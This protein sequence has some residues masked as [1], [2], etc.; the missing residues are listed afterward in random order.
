MGYDISLFSNLHSHSTQRK[1]TPN[2]RNCC[3]FIIHMLKMSIHSQIL[4]WQLKEPFGK[5][6]CLFIPRQNVKSNFKSSRLVPFEGGLESISI[7]YLYVWPTYLWCH[8]KTVSL[9]FEPAIPL[10]SSQINERQL[11]QFGPLYIKGHMDAKNKSG[12]CTWTP[13]S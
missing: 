11:Q 3:E 13:P 1:S 4:G 10:V 8:K 7:W 12:V 2:Q 6:W 9:V 5:W